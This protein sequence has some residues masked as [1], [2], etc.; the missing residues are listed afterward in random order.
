MSCLGILGVTFKNHDVGT[1]WFF[2]LTKRMWPHGQTPPLEKCEQPDLKHPQAMLQNDIC[3]QNSPEGGRV[4]P[5][6][7]RTIRKE[8]KISRL[9]HSNV[10]CIL[11]S[12]TILPTFDP[13]GLHFQF[14]PPN[15][16]GFIFW[17]G[18]PSLYSV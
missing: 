4:S 16:S 6:G 7:L 8:P 15:A 10:V 18:R 12:Y 13:V 1:L 9:T 2:C 14:R 11:P 3:S 5:P 17:P